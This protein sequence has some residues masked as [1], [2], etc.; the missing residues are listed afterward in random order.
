LFDFD[1]TITHKAMF[2]DF[3]RF[4]VSRRRRLLGAAVFAPLVVGYKLGLVSG[5][6]IRAS[7]V[8]FG[9]GG[10]SAEHVQAM[11]RRFSDD[12]L[13]TVLRPMALD[14]I[15]WHKAPGDRIIVVSGALDIYLSHW[16][17]QHGLDLICS[18]LEIADGLLTGRYRGFQC[19]GAEK[20]RRV[21]EAC[22]LERFSAVYAYGDTE[23]DLDMRSRPTRN[24]TAG[25]RWPSRPFM[26]CPCHRTS[27]AW[28]FGRI[29]PTVIR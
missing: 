10:V 9:F 11:G 17:P 24:I 5:N 15:Q 3:M 1:G 6:A 26:T 20:A 28:R 13:S 19:V 14:R 21:R 23:E 4:V 12:V 7:L 29:V 27:A 8:R 2:A 16:C 22:S 18:R 25:R